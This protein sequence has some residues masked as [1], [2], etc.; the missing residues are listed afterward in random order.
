M[1]LMLAM[2]PNR[3]ANSWKF[4]DYYLELFL[5]FGLYSPEDLQNT[6]KPLDD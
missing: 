4:F 6:E 3:G 5:A 1:E 2:L